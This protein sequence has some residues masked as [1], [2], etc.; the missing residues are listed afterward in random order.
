MM[1]PM[2]DI[3]STNGASEAEN[4]QSEG[5]HL[6][7]QPP[8]ENQTET[9][10]TDA[11]SD[12]CSSCCS[13]FGS[14]GISRNKIEP[15]IFQPINDIYLQ[16]KPNRRIRVIHLNGQGA[17]PVITPYYIQNSNSNSDSDDEEYWF[18]N[19][20]PKR[21]KIKQPPVKNL[22]KRI[23]HKLEPQTRPTFE[24]LSPSSLLNNSIQGRLPRKT[25]L[26][27]KS[28]VDDEEYD[29]DEPPRSNET[30]PSMNKSHV[31]IKSQKPDHQDVI[32]LPEPGESSTDDPNDEIDAKES[33]EES[34]DKSNKHCQDH[35]HDSILEGM[36]G[37]QD[38]TASIEEA[39]QK[40]GGMANVAFESEEDSPDTAIQV[41]KCYC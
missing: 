9:D 38:V 24:Q 27:T 8:E 20:D 11:T 21:P 1:V 30:S 26:T 41:K 37:H 31:N 32:T 4:D 28:D 15:V 14:Q 6:P 12:K 25:I 29:E 34:D 18:Q 5:E 17:L 23:F 40:M 22:P 35:D 7:D 3:P 39:G 19:A 16:L 13:C 10:D 33:S 2:E 36:A